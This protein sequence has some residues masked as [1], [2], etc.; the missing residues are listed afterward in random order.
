MDLK[1]IYSGVTSYEARKHVLPHCCDKKKDKLMN[2]TKNMALEL[3]CI[4]FI[5]LFKIEGTWDKIGHRIPPPS[6]KN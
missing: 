2:I 6:L 5:S 3:V 1:F 4:T